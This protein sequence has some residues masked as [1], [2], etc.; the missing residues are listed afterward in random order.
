MQTAG[1][2]IGVV[3][4]VLIGFGH[5]WVK[6]LLRRFGVYS[7]LA[8]AVVGLILVNASL[9]I[10]DVLISAMLGVAGFTTLWG[11]YEIIQHRRE[12]EFKRES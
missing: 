5:W 10:S 1:I 3:S 12:F 6:Q 11:A 4:L 8:I 7:W 2:V 9:F